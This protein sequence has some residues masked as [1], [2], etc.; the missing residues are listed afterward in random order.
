MEAAQIEA[1]PE[2]DFPLGQRLFALWRADAPHAHAT[3]S[4]RRGELSAGR[5]TDQGV[6]LTGVRCYQ[7]LVVVE[8]PT[9]GLRLT[10]FEIGR[11]SGRE[12]V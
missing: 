3:S 5:P 7:I 6:V 9:P 12:R 11:A 8:R 2:Y 4:L 1:G 10:L